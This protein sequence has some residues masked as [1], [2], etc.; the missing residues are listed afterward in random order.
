[1]TTRMEKRN[2]LDT[3]DKKLSWPIFSL[4]IGPMEWALSVPGVWHGVPMCALVWMPCVLFGIDLKNQSDRVQWMIAVVLPFF[5]YLFVR[6]IALIRNG[7]HYPMYDRKHLIKFLFGSLIAM[8]LFQKQDPRAMAL[9]C[10]YIASYL[11]T[12]IFVAA[13]KVHTKRM[14]PGIAMRIRLNGVRR[15]LH[16]LNY[17]GRKGNTVF[18]SFPSG[19]VAGAMVFSMALFMSTNL[20]FL[21]FAFVSMSALG[22]MYFWAHHL[23]DVS[24]GALIALICCT[25]LDTAIGW[26]NFNVLYLVVIGALSRYGIKYFYSRPRDLPKQF[27]EKKSPVKVKKAKQLW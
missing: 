3:V 9:P 13:L 16:T 25:I 8:Y 19:D 7:D 26:Q 27:Q 10:F 14:R 24:V 18:E 5:V 21:S 22:R 12:Q 15:Y 2:C 23:F 17:H 20:G 1:M 6:W 4:E 11:F